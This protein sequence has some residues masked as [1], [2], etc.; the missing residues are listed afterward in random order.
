MNYIKQ[1]HLAL[2]IIAW[3]VGSAFIGGGASFG[4]Y[5]ATTIT[6]PWTFQ[7]DVTLTGSGSDL[8]VS[9]DVTIAGRNL[10]VTT[11][12]TATSSLVIGCIT[13]YA[14]STA[15][16]LHMVA[17]TSPTLPATAVGVVTLNY[18][19]CPF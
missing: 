12:D 15:T 10:T 4:G 2:L 18:G 6:N 8:T 16:P 13:T 1:N 9:G 5:D 17:S 7:D 19:A 3:L 14:T 11:S